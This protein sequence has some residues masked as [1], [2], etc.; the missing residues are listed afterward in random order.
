MHITLFYCFVC[1]L[2]AHIH[3]AKSYYFVKD[4]SYVSAAYVIS[5]R[6]KMLKP[7]R[8]FLR[9]SNIHVGSFSCK[10]SLT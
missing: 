9:I 3:C 4:V 2:T 5:R 10:G 7:G 8:I 6:E 1:L